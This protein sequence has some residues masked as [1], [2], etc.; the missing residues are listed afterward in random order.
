MN[1][2]MWRHLLT[3]NP[4]RALLGDQADLIGQP[5]EPTECVVYS[6]WIPILHPMTNERVNVKATIHDHICVA[7]AVQDLEEQYAIPSPHNTPDDYNGWM[8]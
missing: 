8:D 5:D 6:A 1:E 3:D 2:D 4:L 7:E